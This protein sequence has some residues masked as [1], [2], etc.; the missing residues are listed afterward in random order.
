MIV[1][2]ATFR[3]AEKL[4]FLVL[5]GVNG[6][7]KS[8]LQAAIVAELNKRGF[9]T[10]ATREPGS[11]PLG[12]R[13]RSIVL[14]CA[15]GELTPLAELFLFSADRCEHVARVIRPGLSSGKI[16]ISDRYFYSTI[17]F[18]GQGRGIDQ[19]TI[20]NVN[21]FAIQG[22]LPDLVLLLD[23][24]PSVG[25][26]RNRGASMQSKG[27]DTFESHAAEFHNRV[28]N[29]FLEMAKLRPEPFLLLSAA[30]PKDIVFQDA[31]KV[32]EKHL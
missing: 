17:A 28:R 13:L 15:A 1:D 16:V 24:D 7:G 30:K 27:G 6:A 20:R 10:V 21:E 2:A 8:T 14:G 18:Q 32:I 25:L 4:R 23:L 26:A 9:E 31:W 11:T 5:E 12:E 22:T 19:D 3:P 29:S